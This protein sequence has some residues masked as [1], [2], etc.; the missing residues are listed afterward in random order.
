MID[1]NH[2]SQAEYPVWAPLDREALGRWSAGEGTAEDQALLARQI[3]DLL[4]AVSR[5]LTHVGRQF[6]DG[7][8]IAIYEHALPLVEMIVKGFTD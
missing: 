8:D 6:D 4:Y 1:V 5:N 3:T 2:T 7:Q